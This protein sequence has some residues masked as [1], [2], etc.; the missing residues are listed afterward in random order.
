MMNVYIDSHI[1]DMSATEM[2]D[3][4]SCLPEWRREKALSFRFDI[5]RMLCAKSYLLLKKG[6]CEDFG[7]I[8]NPAFSYSEHGKPFLKERKD[9]HF[10][11]SHCHHGVLCVIG[12]GPVGCDI[13]D[14]QKE[15]DID[16]ANFC[17]SRIEVDAM[18]ASSNPGIEFVKM[19]TQKE[20]VL[21]LLGSGLIDDMKTLL[22]TDFL[23][24]IDLRTEVNG[25][26]GYVSTVCE[27][28]LDG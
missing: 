12:K 6:L 3:A 1:Q 18:L 25:Q 26:D 5:D 14:V 21:K 19:W 24:K 23:Q 22:S 20:A 28:K 8:G 15:I 27:Y 16:V 11:L 4:L 9:I 7:F 13:E 2:E 17:F 10:N